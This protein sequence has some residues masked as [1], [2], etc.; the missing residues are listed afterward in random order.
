TGQPVRRI[1]D[2]WIFQPGFPMVRPT[3]GAVEQ[4]RFTYTE[5]PD[6]TR[7]AIPLPA[8]IHSNGGTETRS[9]LLS[10]DQVA[11][12]APAD[13]L[14]VLNAGGDGFYRVGYPATWRDRLLDSGVLETKERAALADD[15][16]ALVLAGEARADEFLT[17]AERY[18]NETD[19]IVWRVLS[20]H[21]R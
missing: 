20:S 4:R 15:L 5:T 11:I 19:L 7:W 17:S 12:D 6:N 8:R 1:M 3:N 9:V 2:S 14:V 16:W 13:A 10:G 18:A 21:L